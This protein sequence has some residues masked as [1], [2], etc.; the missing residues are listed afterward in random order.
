MSVAS[1]LELRISTYCG[2]L[3]LCMSRSA[4]CATEC[5]CWLCCVPMTCCSTLVVCMLADVHRYMWTFW[6]SCT[7]AVHL[8][9]THASRYIKSDRWHVACLV[10]G[11][12]G[13]NNYD[14]VM[15]NIL[16]ICA[17]VNNGN[18]LNVSVY[19]CGCVSLLVC[20]HLQVCIAC[21]VALHV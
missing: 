13:W 21:I 3:M 2:L 14:W 10:C 9:S 11:L 5:F 17:S 4:T 20:I 15:S 12:W 19:L 6:T 8:W 16:D 7:N 18:W 1:S